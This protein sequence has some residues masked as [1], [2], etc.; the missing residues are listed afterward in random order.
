MKTLRFKYPSLIMLSFF[1]LFIVDLSFSS[2]AASPGEGGG[3][4]PISLL[5]KAKIAEKGLSI[6][7]NKIYSPDGKGLIN[8]IVRIGGC[9]GSFVS[10]DGLILTNH[11]CVFSQLK[12]HS[13]DDKNYMES[14][15]RASEHGGE[16]PLKNLNVK[17]M[18]DYKDVSEEVIKALDTFSDPV[19]RQ[20]QLNEN[21]QAVKQKYQEKFPQY[22]VEVSEMLTGESYV[23]FKYQKLK[24]LRLV[25]VPPRTVGEFGGASDNW[26]WPRHTGDFSFVRAYVGPNG[27][28]AEYSENNVPFEP[29]KHLE[30]NPEGVQSKDFVFMLGYP[31]RTYRHRSSAFLRYHK[32]VQLPYIANL[33]EWKIEKMRTLNQRDT[34]KQ[35]HYDPKIKRLSNVAK[36]Y[37]GKLETME[38]IR[39]L[40]KRRDEEKNVFRRLGRVSPE[41][42]KNFV[43]I[44]GQLDSLYGQV[45]KRGKKILWYFQLFNSSNALS[46]SRD[47]WNFRQKA[48]AIDDESSLDK[49][50]FIESYKKNI[51][52]MDPYTDSLFLKKLLKQ[53]VN[54]KKGNAISALK[55][56]FSD[57]TVQSLINQV[58]RG[59][60]GTLL[61]TTKVFRLIR[62]KPKRLKDQRFPLVKLWGA[63]RSDFASL[64]KFR[65]KTFS[66]IESL[67][68]HYVNLKQKAKEALFIPDAN[69]TLRLTYGRVKGYDP[70]DAVRYKPFTT[71]AGYQDKAEPAGPYEPF[72]AMMDAIL[73]VRQSDFQNEAINDVPICFLYNTDTSGGN[74]GSPVLDEKGRLVGLNF[75][76]TYRGTITDY[77]W[78]DQYSR[79]IGV[80]VR[81]MLW[82]MKEVGEATHLIKEMGVQVNKD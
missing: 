17:I 64:Q 40:R 13:T 25:Y 26:E 51:R 82:Y 77:E 48:V 23:L 30:V 57:K 52:Q 35:V 34:G 11:H 31:G 56:Y 60:K 18:K 1:S 63:I 27:E 46:M 22:T 8:S 39:L 9:T 21:Q 55:G 81:F 53:G 61:D 74:S 65:R 76:R 3:M 44:T 20:N 59:G 42:Q 71:L 50:G 43:S 12:K 70:R 19:K 32:E 5:K 15:F 4:Y 24:D 10:E 29:Q 62:E 16:I 73:G 72:N 45:I 69:G 28:P 66:R 38:S 75:D 37:R 78:S 67:R 14:G 80:D 58:Y 49:K 2:K 54:F 6:P 47:L 41:N 33:F 7:L 68:P 79:S 36:N